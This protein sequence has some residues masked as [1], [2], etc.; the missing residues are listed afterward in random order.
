MYICVRR[1]R[2]FF[3]YRYKE[4]AKKKEKKKE[5]SHYLQW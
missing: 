2:I 3:T 4:I 1:E 5:A